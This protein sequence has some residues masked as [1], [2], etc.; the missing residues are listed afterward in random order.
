MAVYLD[1]AAVD[2]LEVVEAAQEVDLP[3]PDGP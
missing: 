1:P 2:L 3:P